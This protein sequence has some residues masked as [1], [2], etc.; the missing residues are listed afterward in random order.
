[1]DL[2]S[3]TM[4]I[5]TMPWTEWMELDESFLLHQRIRSFRVN[6]Y[7]KTVLRVLP[8]REDESVKVAGGGGAGSWFQERFSCI[9]GR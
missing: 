1:M 5:R 9:C 6:H 3:V 7:G 4:G 2:F 8:A